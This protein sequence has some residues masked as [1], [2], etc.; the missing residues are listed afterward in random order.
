MD[1]ETRVSTV[2]EALPHDSAEGH[3]SGAALYT[4]DLPEPRNLL[5]L[6]AGMSARAHARIKRI[7]LSAVTEAPGV[8]AVMTAADIPGANNY[9]A[10]AEDDPIFASDIVQYV[11]QPVFAVAAESVDQARR[12]TTL[13]RIDYEELPAILDAESAVKKNSFVLPTEKLARGNAADAIAAAKHRL[14]GQVALGGQDQFYLEGQIAMAIPLE[15]DEMQVYSSTQYPGEVQQKVAHAIGTKAKD[16]VVECRRM[17]GG[18]GGKE[19]QPALIACIAALMAHRTGRAAKLRLDRDTDMIM[20][21]K[22]HDYSI[23]YNVGFDEQGVITGIDFDFA[24]RC[25]MSADLSGPVNDRTMFHADNAYFLEQVNI[26]SHRCKTHTVSNTA[27]RG[28][29]GPQGMFAIEY[30]MDDIARHLEK[31]PLDVRRAN[32]YGIDERNET[33]YGQLVKDNVIHQIVDRLEDTADYRQRYQ[34]I[35]DFNAKTPLQKRG[36]ALTPVKFGISFTATHLNQAGALVHVYTDGTVRLNHGGTEMGQGLYIKVAQVVADELQIDLDRI[37][38]TAADTSKVPNASAT[39]ASAG[40][41]LNGK[42]AQAAAR[43]IKKRLTRFACE[44]F[45]VAKGDIVYTR[46]QVRIGKQ[47]LSFAELV[48]LAYMARVSLSATGFYKTP[49]IHY[50]RATFSGRPFFYYAYGAAVSEVIIDVL[51]G[52]HRLLRVDI[53]HDCGR[54]LNPAVDLGQIEGGFIQG[55]GWLTS[56]ELWWNESGELMTHAPSTYKIPT[57]SDL[58]PDFRVEMLQ[59]ADNREKTIHRSKAVGEPPLML[60]LSA[61]FALR[62]AVASVSNYRRSPDLQAPATPEAV[63]QAVTAQ[64][65]ERAK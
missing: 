20:T 41:D 13:A 44:H 62:D 31:D 27:F 46:N 60:S 29:G 22:R 14:S 49:K 8:V 58:P 59:S 34:A 35:R 50:D 57:C 54:S 36:I 25:G 21:G 53:V 55:Y 15:A 10:M 19:T 2:G 1:A 45:S 32:F 11:G 18:F 38:L 24:S 4:D 12:A 7:D 52:E 26:V 48:H 33:P 6:A 43:K 37:K 51:T 56:E 63:L 23:A 3:V 17:G 42:A 39:A 61:F 28:F 30:A 47:H 40:S 16:V 64:K 5:H 9:G 65:A